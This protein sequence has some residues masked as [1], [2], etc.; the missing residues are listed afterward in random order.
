MPGEQVS[1]GLSRAR[2]EQ[3]IRAGGSVMIGR[4]IINRL[5]D[6]PGDEVLAERG[7]ADPQQVLAD[8]RRQQEELRA[9]EAAVLRQLPPPPPAPPVATDSTPEEESEPEE[10]D[11]GDT[12]DEYADLD[13]A[14]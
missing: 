8:I 4:R 13:E 3:E 12:L 2:L 14:E 1:G 9:R 6:L 10:G 5:E 7:L 11:D